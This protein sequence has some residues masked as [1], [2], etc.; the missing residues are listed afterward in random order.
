LNS[1]SGDDVQSLMLG[2]AALASFYGS[3]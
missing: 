3:R 2:F 1:F